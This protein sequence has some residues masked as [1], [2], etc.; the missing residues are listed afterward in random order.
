MK[1]YPYQEV[2]AAWLRTRKIALL[3]DEMGVGK[4]PQAA[5]AASTLARVLVI[6]PAVARYNWQREIE[7]WTGRSAQVLL[8]F[9]DRA[10]ADW[11]V[12][13]YDYA[14][15]RADTLI[16]V[17]PWSVLILDEAHFVKGLNTER[18]KAI[19]GEQGIVRVC[20]RLWCLTGTPMINSPAE[21]WLLLRLAGKTSMTY[22]RWVERYCT[23]YWD[24]RQHRIT[25]ATTHATK[26]EELRMMLRDPDFLLRR[27]KAEVLSD[28]PP[29]EYT[30]LTVG[31]AMLKWTD[32]LPAF[33]DDMLSHRELNDLS[34][35]KKLAL[36]RE[37]VEKAFGREHWLTA[38]GMAVL[39]SLSSGTSN[40]RRYVG[41]QKVQPL[42]E[43]L[44]TELEEDLTKKVVI[45][46][47]H[48]AV[49]AALRD[50]L[51]SFSPRLL[52]GGTNPGRRQ[53][54][55]ESFQ[56]EPQCRV[57]VGQV[58]AC[59][60]AI[61]LTAATEVIILEPP[62]TSADTAQAI[63]RCHRPG[64]TRPLRVR[65]VQ[66]QE[67]LDQAI[68]ATIRRKTEQIAG[69]V[70]ADPDRDIPKDPEELKHLW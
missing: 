37:L 22:D 56:T 54:Y 14:R 15:E 24:G 16:A 68:M 65:F 45:F 20:D 11:V 49:G 60:T 9:I 3:G 67:S 58:L 34:I 40:L 41:L 26:I 4:T 7:R 12:C 32:L 39:E 19:L 25:G 50:G 57:F 61:N 1:L 51:K 70:D 27:M 29:I 17:G 35:N 52:F 30:E 18:T 13:S 46:F 66:L 28:L 36:E 55:I 42:V 21:V 8:E 5:A 63:A 23:T 44:R 33:P 31:A 48:K 2:G 38:Q 10:R 6:C 64:Q 43:I 59:G 53:R 62:W 47:I 69:I